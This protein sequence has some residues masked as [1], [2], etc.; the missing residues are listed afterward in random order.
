MNNPTVDVTID[1][2]VYTIDVKKAKDRG[3]LLKKFVS[4]KIGQRFLYIE[5]DIRE[6]YILA[7]VDTVYTG[8][9]QMVSLISLASGNRWI[10]PVKVLNV[11][12]ITQK[13]WSQITGNQSN[14]FV[15][16]RELTSPGIPVK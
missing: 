9:G 1:G 8:M 4:P 5:G 6:E 13:E 12:A 15:Q 7:L 14:M 11:D 10:P 3:C 16:K 2:T